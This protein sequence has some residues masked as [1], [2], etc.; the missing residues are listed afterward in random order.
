MIVRSITRYARIRKIPKLQNPAQRINPRSSFS[1]SST[2]ST[3][4]ATPSPGSSPASM[5]G[6][7]TTECDKIAPRFE[8][9]ASQ[10]QIL[11]TP[12]EFYD[13]LKVRDYLLEGW[14]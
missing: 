5:L 4:S 3:T 8:V 6:A 2:N 1:T 14:R 13:T 12:S 11:R 10:I 9:E 7:F